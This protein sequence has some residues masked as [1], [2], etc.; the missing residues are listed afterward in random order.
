MKM[1]TRTTLQVAFFLAV[2][3]INALVHAAAQT[4]GGAVSLTR[5]MSGSK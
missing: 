4:K 2:F 3:L 5:A 1:R